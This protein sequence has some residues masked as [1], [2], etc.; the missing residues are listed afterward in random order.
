MQKIKAL[1]EELPI[2][3]VEQDPDQPRKDFGVSGD[4][5]RLL[6]SIETYGIE[7]PLKVSKHDDNTYRLIDGHR[8]YKCA[9]KLG[10]KTVPCRVYPKMTEGE[11]EARRYEIQNNR[12]NWKPMEKANSLHRIKSK[13]GFKNNRELADILGISITVVQNSLQLR[14]TKVD[15]VELMEKYQ[16]STSNRTEFIRLKS[17]LRKI[18][19]LEIDD[20]V[21]VIFEKVQNNIIRNAKDF[22]KLGKIFLRATANEN[23]LYAFLTN[24]DMTISELDQRTIQSGFSLLLEQAIQAITAKRKDAVAFSS[25]EKGLLSQLGDILKKVL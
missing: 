5:N 7:E 20:I 22:R 3:Q 11:F 18:K 13:F 19:E 23:E 6:V 10:L 1:F 17:K 21:K 4:Q 2:E 25:K 12:R 9:Q 24:P 8:R 14:D 15:Y 16:L